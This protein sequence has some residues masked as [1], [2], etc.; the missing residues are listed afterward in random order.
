ME[1]LLDRIRSTP[2]IL[3]ALPLADELAAHAAR[4]TPGRT[5]SAARS[6]LTAA[7]LDRAD[8]PTAIA[9]ARALAGL[10]GDEPLARL[11]EMLEA[12][13]WLAPHVADTLAD[14][15]P[16][17]CLVAP[18]VSLLES[19]GLSGM[20]AQ[21]A[22]VR[23]ASQGDARIAAAISDLLRR[24]V[25]P[26]PRA[27]AVETLALVVREG[28]WLA[29]IARDDDEPLEVRLAAV[30]ALGDRP[31]MQEPAL[32]SLASRDDA[33]SDTARLALLDGRLDR[34]TGAPPDALG[35]RLHIAQVHLGGRLDLS[36]AHAGEGSTGGVAT[37]LV[38][39]GEALVHDPRVDAVTT[40]GRGTAMDALVAMG[41]GDGAH[42][43]SSVPL[44]A[45]EHSA[46]NG[47]WPALV[48]AERG[49]ARI[50]RRRRPTLLH[51]RMADVGSLAAAR[52]ARRWRLPLV[53]TLAPDPHALI[54]QAEGSGEVDRVSFGPADAREAWWYR[55]RLVRSLADAA[56]QVVLLPRPDLAPRLGR[57]MGLDVVAEPQRFHVV[58]EGIDVARVR[59]ARIAAAGLDP[60]PSALPEDEA[61]VVAD[62][63][64]AIEALG[65]TRRGLPIVVSVGRLAEV[66]G[67]ARLA[68]AF[69]DDASLRRRATLV[70]VGGGL[71]DPTPEERGELQRIEAAR[72]ACPELGSALVMLGHRPHRDVLR[73]LAFADAGLPGLIA[74]GGAY[75]CASRKEEFG[76]AIIEALAVG[77]PVLAPHAGGP[78]AYVDEGVTGHLVDTLDGPALAAGIHRA[79][80]LSTRPGR[81]VQARRLVTERFTIEAMST[82]LVPVY[83]VARE[84]RSV[85]AA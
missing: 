66:K 1:T 34:G 62:L 23:W 22:L 49:L 72:A 6:A 45:H 41:L 27:R 44:G 52:I 71:E 74:S 30:A 9:A 3:D 81:A 19:G 43:V 83:A 26:A 10:P 67:M 12:G 58:P 51:L 55:A 65:R 13:E 76:L 31:G 5:L 56:R 21:R 17:E 60:D 63:R 20:L 24:V 29:R 15:T 48:A 8:A 42:A 53:F 73:V 28:G 69:A 47:A 16:D 82:A 18:L 38:Q 37:L 40:V 79:L 77:L 54:A 70:I 68:E 32:R 2:S 11:I 39:L 33:L 57:L 14:R 36:L 78:A 35:D 75:V 59:T 80:D 7:T 46:F 85:A 61:P 50:M 25:A 84:A 64:T 4:L